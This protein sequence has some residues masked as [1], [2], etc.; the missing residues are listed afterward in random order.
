MDKLTEVDRKVV[1]KVSINAKKN[2]FEYWRAQPFEFR[3]AAL[4]NIRLEYNRWKYGPQ[5]GFQRVYSIVK[6]K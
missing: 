5:Q 2:D 6:R 4:E 1:N 3:L